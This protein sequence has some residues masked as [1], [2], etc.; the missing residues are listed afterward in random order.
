[1][2]KREAAEKIKALNELTGAGLEVEGIKNGDITLRGNFPADVLVRIIEEIKA[3]DSREGFL[4]AVIE[5]RFTEAEIQEKAE[6]Y[7]FSLDKRYAALLIEQSR[8]GVSAGLLAEIFA[9]EGD[10]VIMPLNEHSILFIKE[11][12]GKKEKDMLNKTAGSIVSTVNTELM[13]KVRVSCGR[14]VTGVSRIQDSYLQAKLAMEVAGI[15]YTER[16]VISCDELGIGRLIA[17]L[18]VSLCE[19][20][21]DEIFGEKKKFTLNDDELKMINSYFDRNLSLAETARDL[22]IHRNTLTYRIEKLQKKTGLDIRNF[23]D[24]VTLKIALMVDRYLE[25]KTADA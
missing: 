10:N 7:G 6:R 17:E 11:L 14:P 20:F 4:R 1:M 3:V 12:S 15:F 16:Y 25:Y 2:N 18:P 19:L 9:G 23:D 21:M 22:Y 8:S 13:E 5:G 24:A